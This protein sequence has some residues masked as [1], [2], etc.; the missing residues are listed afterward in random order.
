MAPLDLWHLPLFILTPRWVT[1]DRTCRP[2]VD[3]G[4][5]L[6]APVRLTSLS[7]LD[8]TAKELELL[9]GLGC[10]VILLA[11]LFGKKAPAGSFVSRDLHRG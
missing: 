11:F 7:L 9:N 6:R 4:Q 2:P 10:L 1:I 8:A 3:F 5:T